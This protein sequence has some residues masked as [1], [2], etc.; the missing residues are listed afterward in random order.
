MA[1]GINGGRAAW[2][3]DASAWQFLQRVTASSHRAR[4]NRLHTN[5]RDRAPAQ[6]TGSACGGTRA[7]HPEGRESR[8]RAVGREQSA[9]RPPEPQ[10]TTHMEQLNTQQMVAYK[11][12][13]SCVAA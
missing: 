6:N 10:A 5:V 7:E 8:A 12:A 3:L 2:I 4:R 13:D 1:A 9:P 11:P